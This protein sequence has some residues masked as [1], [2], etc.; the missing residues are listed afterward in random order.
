M[1]T[2]RREALSLVET[3]VVF[4]LT[5]V[6]LAIL[7]PAIQ[8]VRDV[9]HRT[10]C[11]NNLRQIG[12]ALHGYHASSRT[13][14]PGLTSLAS[15]DRYPFLS[16]SARILPYIE[17]DAL[18]ISA[19]RAFDQDAFFRNDPPHTGLHV[20][21][22]SYACD[23]DPRPKL[24][25]FG[26]HSVALTSYLGVE[27]T[28]Q[29]R[30]DGVLYLDS[31]VRLGDIADGS[32]FTLMV[33]ERPASANERFG[34]WYGGWGQSKDGSADVVLGVRELNARAHLEYGA[35]SKGP[36]HFGPGSLR[37]VC[38]MF[39]YWSP[40]IGG[41]ANFLFADASVHFLPYSADDLMPA[42]ATRSGG[43]PVSWT[44]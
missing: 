14:P 8:R 30:E 9:A 10:R 7:L 1:S 41:G 15:G 11:G 42:L 17:Q 28:N 44:D 19:A 35:C 21:L 37:G 20:V 24:A 2:H 6:L 29:Y 13:F 38:D 43:E 26:P 33:G 31:H 27:G 16:W 5:A 4:A 23:S 39:H 22:P 12:V 18:W 34:W 3:L 25:M 36:Y 40:H 32:S